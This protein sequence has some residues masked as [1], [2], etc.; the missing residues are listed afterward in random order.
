MFVCWN[1]T[2]KTY[3]ASCWEGSKPP[4][5]GHSRALLC[6]LLCFINPKLVNRYGPGVSSCLVCSFICL[7]ICLFVC[8]FVGIKP[9]K[10]YSASCWEGSKPPGSGHARVDS[11]NRP[12][13]INWVCVLLCF[14]KPILG[15][16]Y[17]PQ[18]RGFLVSTDL[19]QPGVAG[20]SPCTLTTSLAILIPSSPLRTDPATNAVDN[21][22]Q[23]LTAPC[24][25]RRTPMV[26]L[27]C[28][29]A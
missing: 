12:Q 5:S 7:F 27:C 17:G 15:N 28:G 2:Q 26:L 3:S 8:L 29:G 21:Q 18:S 6:E 14:I 10:L 13:I 20:S 23:A 16:R 24:L 22:G 25:G 9:E 4:G 19:R 1:K 11:V